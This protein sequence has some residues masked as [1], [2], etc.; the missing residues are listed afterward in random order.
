VWDNR[1]NQMDNLRKIC[2]P[3]TVLLLHKIFTNTGQHQQCIKLA[4]E[5]ASESNQLYTVYSKHKL[6]EI[7][8]RIAESSLALMNEKHD[9]FGYVVM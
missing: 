3:D 9:P 8:T 5:L 1:K 4:D 7:L 2:I 6:A